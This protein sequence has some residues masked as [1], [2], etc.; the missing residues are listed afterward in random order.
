MGQRQSSL[1]PRN[2]DSRGP[3]RTM[4]TIAHE[5]HSQAFV[6]MSLEKRLPNEFP[7]ATCRLLKRC[8][9]RF[10]RCSQLDL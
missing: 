6:K 3:L 9:Q 10:A 4:R 1:S 7:L 8:R 2:S 5:D